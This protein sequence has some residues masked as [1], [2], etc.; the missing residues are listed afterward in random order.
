MVGRIAALHFDDRSCTEG[1][2]GGDAPSF[3]SNPY[4]I[5]GSPADLTHSARLAGAVPLENR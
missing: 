2:F 1:R 4:G 5:A 3:I